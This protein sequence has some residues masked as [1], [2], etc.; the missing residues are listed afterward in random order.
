MSVADCTQPFTV[1]IFTNAAT[2]VKTMAT[3]PNTIL[4]H[5]MWSKSLLIS[6]LL[7]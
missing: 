1:D 5:G 3:A 4:S 2:D 7:K 6:H